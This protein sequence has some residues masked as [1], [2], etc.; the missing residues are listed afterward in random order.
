MSYTFG[1]HG[2]AQF[3]YFDESL[4]SPLLARVSL[5]VTESVFCSLTFAAQIL[6]S[7]ADH[8]SNQMFP[9]ATRASKETIKEQR[10]VKFQSL[11][12]QLPFQE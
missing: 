8:E 5:P 6:E 7:E 1:F 2:S 4:A 3:G 10:L 9:K 11:R 12:G